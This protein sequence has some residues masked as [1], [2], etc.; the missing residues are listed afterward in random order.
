[1]VTDHPIQILTL[2][3]S[4]ATLYIHMYYINLHLHVFIYS[5]ENARGQCGQILA[6][7]GRLDEENDEQ[8][9]DSDTADEGDIFQPNKE[10]EGNKFEEN[11]VD[12][13]EG[14]DA[15]GNDDEED[16]PDADVENEDQE[17]DI[18]DMGSDLDQEVDL[19]IAIYDEDDDGVDVGNE[20]EEELDELDAIKVDYSRLSTDL[21]DEVVVF[22]F[23]N[24]RRCFFYWSMEKRE[25]GDGA[26]VLYSTVK[27]K[28]SPFPIEE[29]ENQQPRPM[30]LCSIYRLD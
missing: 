20:I 11:E 16:D 14:G 29:D 13:A 24:G 5:C 8:N 18:A 19:Q 7:A 6:I 23:F 1:M 3:I 2:R 27:R 15:D 26:R 22:V 25:V 12:E 4:K 28:S 17:K 9:D 30:S 10:D 21:W